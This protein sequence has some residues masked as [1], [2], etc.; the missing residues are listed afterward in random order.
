MAA[1]NNKPKP[2]AFISTSI[3]RA[4]LKQPAMESRR[5]RA[6]SNE[7]SHDFMAKMKK[8]GDQS[9]SPSPQPQ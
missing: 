4:D 9:P 6:A 1:T 7:F 2:S 8:G 3:M 5:V